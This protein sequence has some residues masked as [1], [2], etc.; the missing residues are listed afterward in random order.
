MPGN[1][2]AATK[3]PALDRNLEIDE[4]TRRWVI[5]S[6]LS[7][8]FLGAMDGMIITAAMPTIVSDLGGLHLYS[9]AY[10]I[11]FLTRAV[12]LPIFGKL[13]DLYSSKRLFLF[14][15]STFLL[16]SLGAGFSPN[17]TWLIIARAIQGVGAG[18]IFAL[19]FIILATVSTP[20]Q[21]ARTMSLESVAF[22]AASVLGPTLGGVIVTYASWRWIFFIQLPL[23]LLPIVGAAFFLVDLRKRREAVSIDI[24]GIVS[25]S[26]AVLGVLTI[27]TL[28]GQQLAWS[29]P[30]LIMIGVVSFVSAVAFYYAEKR[31]REPIV[32]LTLFRRSAFSLTAASVFAINFGMF[33]LFAYSPL[34]FQGTL[35]YTPLEVG[36]AMLSL[37]VGW[38]LGTVILGQIANRLSH[39]SAAILGSAVVTAGCA[40][41][42]GFHSSTSLTTIL[43]VF[44]LIG[45]GVGFITL[46]NLLVIQNSVEPQ[47]LGVATATF[48][49]AKIFGGTV[50]IGICGS[51]INQR[52]PPALERLRAWA[53]GD[54]PG[55]AAITSG[56]MEQV[57]DPTFQA[58]LAPAVLAKLQQIVLK[59]VTPVF[60]II[61]AVAVVCL[62]L[63]LLLPREL[64]R[65]QD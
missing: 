27:F 64:H 54:D 63:N 61:A 65:S 29:S 17:M 16:A 60:W 24:R 51:V 50:G 55:L 12:T 19:I 3:S 1:N 33:A 62:L 39:K 43:I 28:G 25:L 41:V 4:R 14:A 20:A 31:A 37:S 44:Q 7:A 42:L 26:T 52:L 13:A 8:L 36:W 11:P 53:V 2:T 21:R 48:Q 10:S 9:W 18:G 30:E 34:F 5:A 22:G 45:L 57:L 49:F 15:L 40:V 23:G 47:D 59:N 35:G 56:G 58:Q 32:E 46:A 38:S 6:V